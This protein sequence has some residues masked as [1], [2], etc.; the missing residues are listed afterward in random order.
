MRGLVVLT[1]RA[2]ID[3]RQRR[4]FAVA[5]LAILRHRMRAARFVGAGAIRIG[6]QD[7]VVGAQIRFGDAGCLIATVTSTAG[8]AA[9]MIGGSAAATAAVVALI[10]AAPVIALR[11]APTA[12][13]VALIA[14]APVVGLCTGAPRR[15]VVVECRPRSASALLAPALFASAAAL[16]AT[17]LLFASAPSAFGR[18]RRWCSRAPPR[19]GAASSA[20]SLARCGWATESR[21]KT[22]AISFPSYRTRPRRSLRT[23]GAAPAIAGMFIWWSPSAP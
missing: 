23:P 16:L 5:W 2:R 6:T 7:I 21:W 22:R 3:R 14:A 17:T 11:I 12:A 13:V 10:A 1:R 18:W 19:L 8:F 20:R 9:L 4:R 15:A